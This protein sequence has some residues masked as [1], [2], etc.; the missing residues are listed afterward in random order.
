MGR[1]HLGR[2]GRRGHKGFC[3]VSLREREES[4]RDD[5][6]SHSGAW[7]SAGAHI[8]GG[9]RGCFEDQQKRLMERHTTPSGTGS[10]GFPEGKK[11]HCDGFNAEI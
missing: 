5:S 9:R 7:E 6:E 10:V 4:L 8:Q 3:G 1:R 2:E 11:L